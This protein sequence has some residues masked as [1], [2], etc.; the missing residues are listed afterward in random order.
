MK[1]YLKWRFC[2]HLQNKYRMY[3]EEWFEN[4]TEEQMM[5]FKE[6][7]ERLEKRKN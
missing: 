2:D 7:K 5:Y 4:I 1:E 3:F 6:E